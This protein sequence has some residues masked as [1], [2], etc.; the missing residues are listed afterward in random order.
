MAP[1]DYFGRE[2]RALM[3]RAEAG[4]ATDIVIAGDELCRLFRESVIA[5]EACTNAM[6]AE[7]KPSDIVLIEAG[8]GVWMTVRYLLPRKELWG[9]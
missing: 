1:V 6:R 4:G 9:E 7:L 5:M 8:P 3:S 2:L